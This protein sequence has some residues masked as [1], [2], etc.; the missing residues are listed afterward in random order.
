MSRTTWISLLCL[1]HC[2]LACG[3]G[4]RGDGG[5]DDGGDQGGG[6][7]VFDPGLVTADLAALVCE[8]SSPCDCTMDP[9]D[10]STCVDAV[11]PA[12]AGR[13][14][15]GE[16]LALRYHE[17]C[18]TLVTAYAVALSCRRFGE[19]LD[20]DV[21][22]DVEWAARRC[23][24]LAGEGERGETCSSMK[25]FGF[26]TLGDTCAE[27][28]TCADSRCVELLEASGDA[29]AR[30]DAGFGLSI[31]PPGNRCSDP[32]ADGLVTCER[33]PTAGE[34]CDPFGAP[35]CEGELKCDPTQLV[36]SELPGPGQACLDSQCASGAVCVKEMCQ[37]LPGDS[38][39][40]WQNAC[41]APL[42]CDFNT[43]TCAP[44]AA[45][46]DPCLYPEDCAEGLT[47]SEFVADGV[48]VV[49]P[50]EGEGCF[51]GSYCASGLECAFDN[52]CVRPQPITC[53]LPF[54][55]HRSD[56]LC[57]E[58]EGTNLCQEG[59]DPEDCRTDL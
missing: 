3:G 55:L 29:C 59:T 13:L 39:P 49:L 38:E 44:L 57:D 31:C 20:D 41:A 21:L 43:N 45:E 54:C 30:D 56:G 47:C 9:T 15:E 40:C 37:P 18:L 48:C 8:A 25:G 34:T 1:A 33:T 58:P 17:D 52:T 23:K 46:G 6:G 10:A 14:A 36:C 35:P 42:R 27:G 32:D 7:A 24:P 4:D 28:L 53:V 11:T 22:A 12:L 50:A 2:L 5:A 16:A 19:A 51:G 26:L